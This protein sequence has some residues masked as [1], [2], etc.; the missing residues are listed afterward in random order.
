MRKLGLIGALILTASAG[1]TSHLK[2][3]HAYNFPQVQFREINRTS[4]LSEYVPAEPIIYADLDKD[5]KRDR[6]IIGEDRAV[7]FQNGKET[8]ICDFE[9]DENGLGARVAGDKIIVYSTKGTRAFEY[10]TQ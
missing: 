10:S 9:E 1:C 8:V 3:D 6:I 7:Y 2:S 5:G 4:G